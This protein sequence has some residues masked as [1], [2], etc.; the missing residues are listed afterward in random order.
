[1]KLNLKNSLLLTGISALMLGGFTLVPASADDWGHDIK[2][3]RNDLR[4]DRKDARHDVRDLRYDH[5][6]VNHLDRRLE[7]QTE[8]GRYGMAQRT[9]S[10]IDGERRDIHQDN[11]DLRSD[12]RDIH[13]DK[14][15]LRHDG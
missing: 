5:N 7:N 13:Q 14:R 4:F 8:H 15:D 11:T 2:Q 3:D 12:R 6:Q 9:E 1:M 10:R